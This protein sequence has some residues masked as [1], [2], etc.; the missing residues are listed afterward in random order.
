MIKHITSEEFETLKFKPRGREL[1]P[2]IK[3]IISLD[4][5]KGIV[6]SDGE[7]PFKQAPSTYFVQNSDKFNGMFFRAR[8]LADGGYA[9]IRVA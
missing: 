6:I 4:L 7:W 5:N 3:L 8:K 9:I 1:H 2:T